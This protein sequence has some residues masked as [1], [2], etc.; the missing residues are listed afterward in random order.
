MNPTVLPNPCPKC[1]GNYGLHGPEGTPFVATRHVPAQPAIK[2]GWFR[3][4]RPAIEEHILAHCLD[5]GYEIRIQPLDA[6]QSAQISPLP[7]P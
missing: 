7:T 5:C 1:G 3:K 6:R 2:A 4:A